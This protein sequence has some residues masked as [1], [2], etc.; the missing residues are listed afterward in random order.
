MNFYFLR[1]RSKHTPQK[2]K[3]HKKDTYIHTD[4]LIKTENKL[5]QAMTEP[6]RA[7]NVRIGNSIRTHAKKSIICVC[8]PMYMN[9]YV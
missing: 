2:E 8:M 3:T 4:R 9:S 5:K 7:D 6:T 1:S